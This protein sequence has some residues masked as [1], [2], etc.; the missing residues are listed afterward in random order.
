MVR[1]VFAS[2]YYMTQRRS[3]TLLQK[4]KYNRTNC[5]CP[6]AS[7]YHLN[8]TWH[9][10]LVSTQFVSAAYVSYITGALFKPFFIPLAN[11]DMQI[12]RFWDWFTLEGWAFEVA[13]ARFPHLS[14][15]A[16]EEIQD[17]AVAIHE[18]PLSY[19]ESVSQM[20]PYVGRW[21]DLTRLMHSARIDW[22]CHNYSPS[23][24]YTQALCFRPRWQ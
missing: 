5:T 14:W 13:F 17:Y 8:L 3:H 1:T 11:N 10:L 23:H 19:C 2:S 16:I 7:F 20:Q 22:P 9:W 6:K 12:E 15:N 21:N 18:P 24:G 4:Y